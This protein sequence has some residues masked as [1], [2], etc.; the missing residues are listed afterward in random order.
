MAK[1]TLT[2]PSSLQNEN[3]FIAQVAANNQAIETALENTLSRDGTSPNTMSADL[4]MNSNQILN[5][6]TPTEPND[7]VRL[8]DLEGSVQITAD[9]TE[10]ATPGFASIATIDDTV[11]W[12]KV[13]GVNAVG[14]GGAGI[15]K[16]VLADP[17]NEDAFQS[18]DG[19]WWDLA[20]KYEH[21]EIIDFEYILRKYYTTNDYKT[22]FIE[23]LRILAND[24][25]ST[26]G[27]RLD[28]QGIPMTAREPWIIRAADFDYTATNATRIKRIQNVT[29]DLDDTGSH[30]WSANEYLLS[31]AGHTADGSRLNWF[32]I[33]GLNLNLD[34][35]PVVGLHIASYQH[36]MLKHP[37]M[38]G[39]ADGSIGIYSCGYDRTSGIGATAGVGEDTNANHGCVI[40]DCDISDITGNADTTAI[41]ILTDDGDFNVEGGW[42]TTLGTGIL[43][44]A[45][46]INTRG[47]HYSC[48]VNG[49]GQRRIA[50]QC[51]SPANGV[52]SL[53]D[54]V[55]KGIFVFDCNSNN[56]SGTAGSLFN[57][58]AVKGTMFSVGSASMPVIAGDVDT[59]GFI[60][61]VARNASTAYRNIIIEPNWYGMSGGPAGQELVKFITRDG[62]S[63]STASNIPVKISAPNS[64]GVDVGNL[65][66]NGRVFMAETDEG[67]VNFAPTGGPGIGLELY[68]S[69]ST[70]TN[71][72]IRPSTNAL[73]FATG[74]GSGDPTDRWSVQASGVLRPE[75]DNAYDI[76]TTTKTIKDTYQ[77]GNRIEVVKTAF[78]TA[79]AS[80][81]TLEFTDDTKRK[82]L[83]DSDGRVKGWNRA[84]ARMASIGAVNNSTTSSVTGTTG[85]DDGTGTAIAIANTNYFTRQTRMD[86]ASAA[87]TGA[88]C[89]RRMAA[90]FYTVDP[91]RVTLRFGVETFQTNCAFF[92][93]LKPGGAH[94]NGDPSA[95]TD[96]FGVGI[97]SGQTT[98]R[99]LNNDS[100]GSATATDLGANFPANTS[101]TDFYELMFWWGVGGT[102]I[103]YQLTRF[104]S[105]G[106]AF[107]IS[108]GTVSSNLPTPTTAL[109]VGFLGN[110]RTGSSAMSLAFSQMQAEIG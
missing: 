102:K 1:L 4:D 63:F 95:F 53:N 94:G 27:M 29:I 59:C 45:G 100:A 107:N 18:E 34:Q 69:G 64:G 81:S 6:P 13:A 21:D 32:E 84:G 43:S 31:L 20:P 67:G 49:S 28:C 41:G 16:K 79:P 83:M 105:N 89:G 22:P 58:I 86:S 51:N 103:W 92:A 61:F 62:G 33:D 25:T 57:K 38:I 78:P 60:T 14:D 98:L 108:S 39:L 74:S 68:A 44:R 55:D 110:T 77:T 72:R 97:D 36:M 30:T 17:D 106:T 40:R 76:G 96:C 9:A 66:T 2:D 56:I 15:Y 93:G 54:E 88:D 10:F 48:D 47:V 82:W 26:R 8:T 50:L 52:G 42:L 37:R 71:P 70:T 24:S 73:V 3:S 80:G 35:K 5:L 12:L 46:N 91:G 87:S 85:I 90:N 101:A 104:Q 99:L 109:A 75:A 65:P 7:P 19:A 23:A 11:D